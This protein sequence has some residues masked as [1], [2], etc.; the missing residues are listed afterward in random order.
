MK[1]IIVLKHAGVLLTVMFMVLSTVVVA[2]NTLVDEFMGIPIEPLGDAELTV[3]ENPSKLIVSNIGSSGDDGVLFTPEPVQGGFRHSIDHDSMRALPDGAII[4]EVYSFSGGGYVEKHT[5]SRGNGIF[6]LSVSNLDSAEIIASNKGEIIFKDNIDT[7]GA[8]G[9]ADGGNNDVDVT[10]GALGTCSDGGEMSII[11]WSWGGDIIDWTYGEETFEIDCL[12]IEGETP[13]GGDVTSCAITAMFPSE[14]GLGEFTITYAEACDPPAEP[15][16]DG[17]NSGKTGISHDYTLNNIGIEDVYFLIDWDDGS[18]I[19][20]TDL[21][22]PGITET[23]S[24][25][26]SEDGTYNVKARAMNT[27]GMMSRWA[28]LEVSMP[29]T[30]EINRPILNFLEQHPNMFPIL[31]LILRLINL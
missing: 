16:I 6:E 1:R 15:D 12:T 13:G 5:E 11:G 27:C 23:A 4:T 14:H 26:W 30:K 19:E 17:P 20:S 24:H 2:E 29:K 31:Q 22:S 9:T 8:G 28:E 3:T 18:P 21:T 25:T 10:E 7:A